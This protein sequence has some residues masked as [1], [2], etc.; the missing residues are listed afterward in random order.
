MNIDKFLSQ[1]SNHGLA[2]NN[3]WEVRVYPP[4][5][6]NSAANQLTLDVGGAEI[7]LPGLDL[8]NIPLLEINGAGQFPNVN[9][10]FD[11]PTLGFTTI[12]NGSLIERIN[13]YCAQAQLPEREITNFEWREYGESRQLGVVQSHGKGV[14]LTYY[15]SEN[16]KERFFFEQWQDLIFNSRNKRKSYYSEYISRIE[17]IKYDASWKKQEAIYRLNEAYPTNIAA[18]PLVQEQGSIMRLDLNFKYRNYER[19]K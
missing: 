19:I 7:N 16:M 14:S 8:S 5:A 10:S 12:N 11:L 4:S 17:I 1:V 13:L 9:A 2:R 3:R 18:Q 15:C 6:L